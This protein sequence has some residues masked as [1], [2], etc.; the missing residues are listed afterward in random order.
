MWQLLASK[1]RWRQCKWCDRW[2]AEDA[3]ETWRL[4]YMATGQGRCR[5]CRR[6]QLMKLFV[7]KKE[8]RP[9]EN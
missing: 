6:A 3:R 8:Q 1:Q 2:I 4:D 5:C 9:C 7:I